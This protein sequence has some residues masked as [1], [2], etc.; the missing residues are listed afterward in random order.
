MRLLPSTYALISQYVLKSCAYKPVST[1]L[2]AGI[3]FYKYSRIVSSTSTP[4]LMNKIPIPH[5]FVHDYSGGSLLWTPSGT[6][7]ES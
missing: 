6:H 2:L 3:L 7:E 4:T 5:I 1:V